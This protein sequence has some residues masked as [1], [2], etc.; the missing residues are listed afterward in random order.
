[1]QRLHC[2]VDLGTTSVK[3]ALVDDSGC[4]LCVRARPTPRIDDEGG[5]ATS[6]AV[7][8]SM[9]EEMIAEAWRAAG[10]DAPLRS[11]AVVGVGEDGLNVRHDLTPTGVAL[12]WFDRRAEGEASWLRN[13]RFADPKAGIAIGADRAVA[14][15][16]WTRR[17]RS[18]ELLE[19]KHW[20]ALTDY[21]SAWWTRQPFMSATLA[22][23]TASFDIY[24]RTWMTDLLAEVG[25]PELPELVQA[26][27]VVGPVVQ[28]RLL[29][30]GAASSDTHVVAGGHDHPIAA[31][32][33][34]QISPD[35][36][37]E[38]DGYSKSRLRRGARSD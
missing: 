7:I 11:I 29:E 5:V 34:R 36:R 32:T 2:G 31:Y 35:A 18:Q 1:M 25:A 37:V 14:K 13:S 38:L 3:V 6:G 26:G 24:G 15:W 23:R 12:A 19:A 16:L 17:H 30:C 8:V 28:G 33:L 20:L 4:S 10:G 22:P 27:E 21:A 9:L